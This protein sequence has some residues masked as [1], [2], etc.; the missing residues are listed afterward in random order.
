MLASRPVYPQIAADFGC[1]TQVGRVGEHLAAAHIFRDRTEPVGAPVL[2]PQVN[3]RHDMLAFL[4]QNPGAWQDIVSV[5]RERLR[6][7]PVGLG[8]RQQYA[9]LTEIALLHEE[10]ARMR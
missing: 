2:W 1:K 7:M 6:H 8:F 5:L 4:E 9:D 3:Y 10:R